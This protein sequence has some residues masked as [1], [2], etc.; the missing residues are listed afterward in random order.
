MLQSFFSTASRDSEANYF[1]SNKAVSVRVSGK[2][3]LREN[4]NFTGKE[5]YTSS[6][7]GK[8]SILVIYGNGFLT[9]A[10]VTSIALK[11]IAFKIK[12]SKLV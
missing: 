10:L 11:I 2:G 3:L 1:H 12:T 8:W 6:Y 9:L 5:S 4:D 7:G